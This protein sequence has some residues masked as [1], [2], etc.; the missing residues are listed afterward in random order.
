VYNDNTGSNREEHGATA[1][2]GR[3]RERRVR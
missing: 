2:C 1:P 3:G